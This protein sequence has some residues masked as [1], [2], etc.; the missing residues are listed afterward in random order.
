MWLGLSVI[1]WV[2]LALYFLIVIGIG[3]WSYKKVKDMSDFFMGG[4]RFGKIFMMFFAF[5]AGT[6]SEQAV[7]VVAGTWRAGLAGI[8][9]QFL[10][11]WATPFYW[12]VAPV[13]RR[14]RALTTSDFFEARFGPATATLYSAFG[15][16]TSIVFIGAGLYG[17]G[18]MVSALTGGELETVAKR[19]D[20]T[21][22]ELE[23]RN[24][25]GWFQP[26]KFADIDPKLAADLDK[27]NEIPAEIRKKFDSNI[28]FNKRHRSLSEN[29]KVEVVQAGSHWKLVDADNDRTYAVRLVDEEKDG[30]K[31]TTL[32]IF[33]S[34]KRLLEGYELAILAMTLMFVTYGMAGGLG[35]AIITDFIQG[36]LTITFS[37]LLL[38]FIF[39]KIG[40]W[41]ALQENSD[42]KEGML[43]LVA[44]KDVAEIVGREPITIFYI[45]M[46][47]LT[48][49]A[50]IVVQPHIMGVCGAGKTEFEGRF[51]FTFGNFIKRF[52]TMAWTFTGLACIVWYLGAHS[53][54][55]HE[56]KPTDIKSAE[57]KQLSESERQEILKDR[58][59]YNDLKAITQKDFKN[60]PKAEQDR[61]K[62]VDKGFAD[63]L[64]GKAAYS[65]LGE[66]SPG[67][68]GL[69]LASLLAAIMSSSD[70]QMVVSSGLFTENI[71]KRFLV[72]NKSQRHYLWV[73][74]ISGLLIVIMALI[75]QASFTDVI[76]AL[77]VVIK[78][79][80]ILGIS[81]WCGIVWRGWT[82]AAVWVSAAAAA[83]T[84]AYTAYFPDQIAALSLSVGNM[85][86]NLHGIMNDS[87]TKV[88][89]AWQMMSFMTVGFFAGFLASFITPRTPKHKLDHFFR[90]IHTPVR[91]GEV[92]EK[93]CTLPENPL[94]PVEKI[95]NYED[96]ELSKPTLVG[97]GGFVAAWIVVAAIVGATYWLANTL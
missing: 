93:P 48:A 72:R 83:A 13:M 34:G 45:F 89:D 87:L 18:K 88:A 84:W 14:M 67:L 16:I 5:G 43:S 44:S 57:F 49:L 19:M 39:Q 91:K 10:W 94:P 55:L 96:I 33:N 80:A 42:L 31:K 71:Y 61:V 82:P 8:W 52:C 86:F 69:L 17:S 30:E 97:F 50:G 40:G 81:L 25:R 68:I 63:E 60:L 4:R 2:V 54:L 76:D 53:P 74:R 3:V 15:I 21:L 23:L 32:Q 92:V 26:G 6:S 59:T 29:A 22:P 62:T 73:G 79:P 95:F 1:D 77:R 35:A 20:I 37:F 64:F 51:G 11:L 24:E 75:L 41:G 78:T 36:I 46:L 27:G 66:L 85:E 7:G 70:A 28:A 47:S 65:I 38:P 58:Q 12:I 56:G 90:L 9:W